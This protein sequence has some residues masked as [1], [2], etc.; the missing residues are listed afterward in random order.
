MN[1]AKRKPLFMAFMFQGAPSAAWDTSAALR[2]GRIKQ[3]LEILLNTSPLISFCHCLSAAEKDTTA[4]VRHP[5]KH[6]VVWDYVFLL[7]L[8]ER[9]RVIPAHETAGL[10]VS[11][12]WF[13]PSV[14]LP[15]RNNV[16]AHNSD[17]TSTS[18]GRQQASTGKLASPTRSELAQALLRSQRSPVS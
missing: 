14:N 5:L 2:G 10:A 9:V 16:P 3:G 18:A 4:D 17:D 8:S 7:S 6:S 13:D 15:T 1:Y 11:P 12:D